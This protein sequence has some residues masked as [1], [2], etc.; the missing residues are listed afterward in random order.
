MANISL[1]NLPKIPGRKSFRV[2]RGQGS[3]LGK[4]SGRGMKGQRARSGSKRG[5][6]LMGLKATILK[7]PKLR[8]FHS[9]TKQLAEVTLSTLDKNFKD[10]D[11]VTL[12]TLKKK[13]LVGQHVIGA[14]IIA[15]GE[16]TKKLN[17][18]LQAISAGAKKMIEAKGGSF[19]QIIKEP[20]SLN[21]AQRA[22][23]RKQ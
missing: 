17:V 9:V 12:P 15:T 16:L 13:A 22:E 10:N 8:G 7:L 11:R 2:G 3:G 20:K 21:K 1:S 4:T 18:E 19:K 23:N 6:K 5:L 14:K